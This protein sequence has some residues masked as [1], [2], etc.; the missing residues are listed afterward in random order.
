[1]LSGRSARGPPEVAVD[2]PYPAASRTPAARRQCR[3]NYLRHSQ[4]S[5]FNLHMSQVCDF[6]KHTS[7]GKSI[8]VVIHKIMGYTCR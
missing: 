7:L 6:F 8:I 4:R 2:T 3:K 1:M 5:M